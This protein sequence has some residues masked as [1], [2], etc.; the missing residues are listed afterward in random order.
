MAALRGRH[1]PHGGSAPLSRP[2]P[3]LSI[4]TPT[5]N[6]RARLAA[7]ARSIAAQRGGDFEWVVI[8][9]ASDDGTLDVVAGHAG[10]AAHVV[11]EPDAGIYDA[12]NRGLR[13][14]RGEFVQF[15]NAGDAY[16]GA[17]TLARL[18]ARLRDLPP[19]I[20]MVLVGVRE[21]HGDGATL[22]RLPEPLDAVI[23]HRLPICHQGIL[24]RR[25]RHLA[26][27]YDARYRLAADYAA[28]ATMRGAG[29]TA[30]RLDEVF[31]TFAV[32]RR[33]ASYRHPA[34]FVAE[35]FRAQREV[36]RLPLGHRLRS[37]VRRAASIALVH[38]AAVRP[39]RK[40]A[41]GALTAARA[42]AR[43]LDPRG[44]HGAA[45]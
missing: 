29:A 42:G 4:V 38:L 35:Y 30:A 10:L 1:G 19:D 39:L 21:D 32:D 26:T 9:G 20:D 31:V 12:M 44:P 14:A 3:L 36:L 7:T 24:F 28:V 5:R 37:A 18:A 41:L 13:L 34:R 6:D 16:D 27:P 17:D 11:S 8:D 23:A 15:L 2:A 45:P 25:R 33:S 40:V 43:P 22:T